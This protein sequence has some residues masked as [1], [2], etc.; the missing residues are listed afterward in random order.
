M[1]SLQKLAEFEN[2]YEMVYSYELVK[3][4]VNF[5]YLYVNGWLF[6]F[7]VGFNTHF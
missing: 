3:F 1:T 5:L 2:S 4:D 7:A 6:S